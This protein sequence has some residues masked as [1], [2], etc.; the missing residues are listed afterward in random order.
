MQNCIYSY[1]E[2][3][4]LPKREQNKSLLVLKLELKGRNIRIRRLTMS[5]KS[6]FF[7]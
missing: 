2:K 3:F 5:D 1:A 7:E 6:V 4:S